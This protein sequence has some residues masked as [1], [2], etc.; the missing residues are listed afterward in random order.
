M[1][2][3]STKL[4]Q[5]QHQQQLQGSTTTTTQLTSAAGASISVASTASVPIKPTAAAA[6]VA[7]NHINHNYDMTTVYQRVYASDC[8]HL[9]KIMA[10]NKENNNN[11]NDNGNNIES[12]T[13]AL[14]QQ[15]LLPPNGWQY[16]EHMSPCLQPG[17]IIIG[18]PM[19]I[20]DTYADV[21]LLTTAPPSMS[22]SCLFMVTEIQRTRSINC[23]GKNGRFSVHIR[24]SSLIDHHITSPAAA[25]TISPPLPICMYNVLF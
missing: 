9:L 24:L 14:L 11:S 21:R 12:T 22:T 19:T 6:A 3:K 8:L 1:G 5:H 20:Y 13:P 2:A 16:E 7:T 10:L 4:Q 25:A 23:S 15:H 17:D 18:G